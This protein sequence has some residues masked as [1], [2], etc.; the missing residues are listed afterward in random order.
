MFSGASPVMY[1]ALDVTG[2]SKVIAA[3]DVMK[4]NFENLLDKMLHNS[5]LKTEYEILAHQSQQR[6]F[7]T[8]SFNQAIMQQYEM[9]CQNYNSMLEHLGTHYIPMEELKDLDLK[10]AQAARCGDESAFRKLVFFPAFQDIHRR[11]VER[12]RQ[13]L[14]HTYDKLRED[15]AVL[16]MRYRTRTHGY[17]DAYCVGGGL[18]IGVVTIV[19]A[20]PILI[21]TAI[22]HSI[23]FLVTSLKQKIILSK[24]KEIDAEIKRDFDPHLQETQQ[25]IDDNAENR[26]KQSFFAVS[27]A[28]YEPALLEL[29]KI[30]PAAV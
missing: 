16:E 25:A 6:H 2:P 24:A 23:D 13:G 30:R 21:V 27:K 10:T 7:M 28:R 1:P 9:Y 4:R 11:D 17:K 29:E 8:V 18:V 12:H 14:E 15:E 19:I 3:L 26:L 5:A 20:L 22:I